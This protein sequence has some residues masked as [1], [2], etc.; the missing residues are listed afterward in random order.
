[1]SGRQRLVREIDE[2]GVDEAVRRIWAE[3]TLGRHD[4]LL[5]DNPKLV[6]GEVG[7]RNG[8]VYEQF[9]TAIDLEVELASDMCRFGP[10]VDFLIQDA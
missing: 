1:M 6:G 3:K 5:G 9:G 4:I 8:G 7:S 2:L 10:N